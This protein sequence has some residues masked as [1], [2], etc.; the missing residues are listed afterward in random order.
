MT[1]RKT[2]RE[3]SEEYDV[4]AQQ[5]K[6]I[7]AKKRAALRALPDSICSADAY[8]LKRELSVLYAQQR[9]TKEIADYLKSYYEPHNGRRELFEYK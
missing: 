9:E 3:L 6:R 4:A 7:I 1:K 5:L 8:E 2:L